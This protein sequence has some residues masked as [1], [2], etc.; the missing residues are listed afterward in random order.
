[1]R[2]IRLQFPRAPRHQ[3]NIVA[4]TETCLSLPLNI[5]AVGHSRLLLAMKLM[6]LLPLYRAHYLIYINIYQTLVLEVMSP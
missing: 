1:M 2:N 6:F 5:T 4:L 3:F